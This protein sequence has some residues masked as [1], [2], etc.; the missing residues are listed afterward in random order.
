MM[1]HANLSKIADKHCK[2]DIRTDRLHRWLFSTDAS[3]YEILPAGVA[4]PHD[5]QETSELVRIASNEGIPIIPRGAGTGLS[6]G[7]IGPGLVLNLSR[8][9]NKILE[10]SP[11][12]RQVWV[13]AGVVLDSLN[14]VIKEFGLMFGPDV[15]TSSRATLGGMIANNSSGA[16]V[17]NYGLTIDHVIAIEFVDCY[18]NI[19]LLTKDGSDSW[20]GSKDI[21]EKVLP[22]ADEIRCV[23]HEGVLKRWPGYAL[24]RYLREYPSPVPL[25]GG[26]EGTLGVITRAL[27]NLVP[28]PK[29]RQLI[30]YTFD[31]LE[32]AMVAIEPLMEL[33]PASIEHIDDVLF[34]QTK[35]Q[36]LFQSAREL[37]GL[38]EHNLKS[39]LFVEFFDPD[40]EIIEKSQK[41]KLGIKCITCKTDRERNLLWEFRKAGLSLLTGMKGSAKPA[42]GIEDTA[43][44]PSDLTNY[45][46]ELNE[47]MDKYKLRAS[48]YGHASAGLLH[49]RP[50]LDLH[51]NEE[52]RK[53]RSLAGE[54]FSLVKR[55]K[56]SFTG[57]HGVGVAHSEFMKDQVGEKVFSVMKEVKKVFDPVNLMNPG[58]VVD[59]DTYKFDENIRWRPLRLPFSSKISFKFKDESFLGNLEQCN[60]CGTCIKETPTMCPTYLALREEIMST[61]GRANTIRHA[62]EEWESDRSNI[63]ISELLEAIKYCLS[64][65]A[66]KIECPSNVHMALLKSEL[67]YQLGARYLR[68]TTRWL[69]SNIELIGKLSTLTPTL[70]NLSLKNRP[71]RTLLEKFAGITKNRPLPAFAK[72]PFHKWFYQKHKGWIASPPEIKCRGSV[73]LW[74]DCFTRY[75][76]PEIGKNAVKLL[77]TMGYEV[78]IIPN[79][80]CCGRPAFSVGNLDDAYKRGIRNLKLLST[81]KGILLFLEPSCYTMF[82]EDYAEL[83]IT[84]VEAISSR[85]RLME[86]FLI[87]NLESLRTIVKENPTRRVFALHQHCHAKTSIQADKVRRILSSIPNTEVQILPSACCGMAGAFGL[88]K[89]TYEVSIEVGEMLKKLLENLPQNVEVIASGTSCRQQI[90]F[91]TNRN[92]KHLVTLLTEVL[93]IGD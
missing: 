6:G 38:D 2:Y 18:G 60:G 47:I 84:Q 49:V 91:L 43:V 56:G 74:D 8:Y 69:I 46:R 63:P 21:A 28:I 50:I 48:F 72:K 34:N 89:E 10:I 67:A 23:F 51:S 32:S 12:N 59:I 31:S 82:S 76:E 66:C 39:L 45:V 52:I 92:A 3:I 58:K 81:T 53:F 19:H 17:H 24:D 44:R 70:A 88:L 78:E 41:M 79:H 90:Q 9:M 25:F 80:S 77:N 15:A 1:W 14:E 20:L 64:C 26:S 61:R 86:D 73:I 83:G 37:L 4:F 93:L 68:N 54:V 11:Q 36:V 27:L 71:I 40:E 29:N 62:I 75:Y 42:T 57:E 5:T 85:A 13:E 65:R 22:Y 30:V 33:K 87:E 55:Y 16:F 7:A 35:G